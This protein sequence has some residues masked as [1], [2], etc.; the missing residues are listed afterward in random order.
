M[1]T[2][3]STSLI[4]A[5]SGTFAPLISAAI[6]TPRPSVNI[7]GFTP[8][9]A[10]SVGFGPVRSPLLAPSLRRCRENSISTRCRVAHHSR[11]ATRNESPRTR[12]AAPT[13]ENADGTSSPSRSR[14]A[15]PSTGNRS[16]TGRGCLPSPLALQPAVDHLAASLALAG[17]VARFDATMRQAH[18][19]ILLP[20]TAVDH[21]RSNLSR[22]FR[23]GSKP[24]PLP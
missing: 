3:S 6:G 15:T 5:A 12:Q 11:S 13:S 10:R 20:Q 21:T 4:I 19:R 18:Q 24:L 16:S 2:A 8:L 17:S 23:I 22:G 14:S 7:W 1:T 9:F